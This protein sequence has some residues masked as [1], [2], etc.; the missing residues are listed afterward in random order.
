ME[1]VPKAGNNEETCLLFDYL[2][3]IC[4]G[5]LHFQSEYLKRKIEPLVNDEKWKSLYEYP[6]SLLCDEIEYIR[7]D[8]IKSKENG[9]NIVKSPL[10]KMYTERELNDLN[11]S[12]FYDVNVY[13]GQLSIIAHQINR[14]FHETMRN[15]LK[16][17]ENGKNKENT[18]LYRAGP[19]YATQRPKM[20]TLADNSRLR[21][22]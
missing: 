3:D 22:V 4:K 5:S 16:I 1:E 13:L 14:E 2:L 17:E 12:D 11:L 10:P 20:I 21:R 9:Q 6:E 7:Q 19:I 15:V 18:M 8:F